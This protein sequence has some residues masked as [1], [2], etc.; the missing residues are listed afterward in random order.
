MTSGTTQAPGKSGE[1]AIPG[2]PPSLPR[3]RKGFGA[4]ILPVVS[5]AVIIGLW[6]LAVRGL[7][8]PKYIMPAPTEVFVSM[9]DSW[10]MLWA[11][12]QVTGSEVLLG[13]LLAAVISVPLAYGIAS[14]KLIERA[15]YPVIVVLQTIPKIAVAP[16]FIVWF[17]LGQT[18]KILLTFLL[19]FFPI[20]VDSITGFNSLDP[21]L[22]YI[23]KSMGANRRQAFRYVRLPAALPFIFSGFKVAAVLSVTGAI[24][25]E[26]VGASAGLGYL[27]LRASSNL[28]TALI[29][30]VIVVLS[31]L[32][33]LF[34]YLVEFTERL[35]MPW[36]RKEA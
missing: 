18:P 24:V 19:C 33:L 13:F 32:G 25:A 5:F 16:L 11:G 27:L 22:L 1:A 20:L 34:S 12:A 14:V 29:F 6:Q 7:D 36:Q 26:F 21:R 10:Q 31:M 28:D 4:T 3:R 35:V 23:T 30:A 2:A 15:L 9:R 8:I 17:G